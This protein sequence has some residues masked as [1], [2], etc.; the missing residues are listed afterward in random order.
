MAA[1]D[2]ALAA[3]PKNIN[4]MILKGRAL[5]ADARGKGPGADW[6]QVRRYLIQANR[7][8]TENAEPLFLYY[9]TFLAARQKPSEDAIKG[10]Y[11][12]HLLAPHD[13]GLRY[14]VVRQHLIDNDLKAAQK[15]FAPIISNPHIELE[16]RP[17]LTEAMDMM[18]AG[19]RDGAM[20]ALAADLRGE[21]GGGES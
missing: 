11:Y 4:A 2:R 15:S 7:A 5:L 21:R 13:V 9:Q 3:D 18:R 14:A 17:K 19:D 6:T 1:A 10:L 20:A 12:A 16:K 8:D